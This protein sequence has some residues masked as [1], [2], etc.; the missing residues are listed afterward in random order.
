VKEERN[1]PVDVSIEVSFADGKLTSAIADAMGADAGDAKFPFSIS[2]NGPDLTIRPAKALDA[3]DAEAFLN[4]A[5]SLLRTAY[6]S[7]VSVRS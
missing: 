4:S 2:V 5:L 6:R 1:P 3:G 7:V